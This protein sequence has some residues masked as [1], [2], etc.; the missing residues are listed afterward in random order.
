M[1]TTNIIFEEKKKYRIT[2]PDDDPNMFMEFIVCSIDEPK[3]EIYVKV[4]SPISAHTGIVL[5]SFRT[6]GNKIE[7]IN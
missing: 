4:T 1:D 7:L 5:S 2:K 6:S 3:D